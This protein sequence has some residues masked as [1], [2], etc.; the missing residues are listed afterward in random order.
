MTFAGAALA[1]LQQ[2]SKMEPVEAVKYAR[3]MDEM[4][5]RNTL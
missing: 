3:F 4:S 2:C 1:Y 5:L